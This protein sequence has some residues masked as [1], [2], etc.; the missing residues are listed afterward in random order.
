[1]VLWL[2]LPFSYKGGSPLELQYSCSLLAARIGS[3][4]LLRS[5]PTLTC[6]ELVVCAN[7]LFGRISLVGLKN[8]LSPTSSGGSP[9]QFH[10][11][12]SLHYRSTLVEISPAI[13]GFFSVAALVVAVAPS[14]LCVISRVVDWR[15]Q[16][17]Y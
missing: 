12:F 2:D 9:S 1:M 14:T 8:F 16:R 10:S 17:I 6:S 3:A 5:L 4:T 7:V 11:L 13:V 15:G